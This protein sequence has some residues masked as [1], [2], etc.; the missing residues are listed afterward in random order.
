[1]GKFFS[2]CTQVYFGE[3]FLRKFFGVSLM[4]SRGL[5]FVKSSVGY[6]RNFISLTDHSYKR[7][8][9]ISTTTFDLALSLSLSLSL[10]LFFNQPHTHTHTHKFTHTLRHPLLR[11]FIALMR[12]HKEEDFLTVSNIQCVPTL[13]HLKRHTR[14][15]H[16][17]TYTHCPSDSNDSLCPLQTQTQTVTHSLNVVVSLQL[18]RLI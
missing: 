4:H 12:M 5:K 11:Y 7:I 18:I 10:S 3:N 6:H 13:F 1:M 2:A 15:H 16:T 17:R 8:T 9:R 14:T